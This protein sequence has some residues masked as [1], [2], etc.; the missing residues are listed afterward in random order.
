MLRVLASFS[1]SVRRY[2]GGGQVGAAAVV[3]LPDAADL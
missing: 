2:T 3:P 1:S